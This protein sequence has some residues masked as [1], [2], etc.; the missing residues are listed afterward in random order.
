MGGGGKAIIYWL[1]TPRTPGPVGAASAVCS[2][3][4]DAQHVHKLSSDLGVVTTYCI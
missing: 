4:P 3:Q 2:V 1:H